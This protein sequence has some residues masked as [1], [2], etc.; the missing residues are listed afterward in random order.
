MPPRELR[1]VP[2]R[3]GGGVPERLIEGSDEIVEDIERVR[4]DD[5][6]VVIGS[7]VIRDEAR[8]FDLVVPRLA[9]SD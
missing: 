4:R 5:E 2:R 9:K 8:G 3:N 1:Y 6:F 7:E